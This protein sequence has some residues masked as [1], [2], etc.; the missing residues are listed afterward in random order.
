ML[1]VL[2]YQ[3][4]V[5]N[6]SILF[7]EKCVKDMVYDN[8]CYEKSGIYLQTRNQILYCWCKS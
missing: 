4:T 8:N 2:G 5:T 3:V 1:K 7:H 6:V